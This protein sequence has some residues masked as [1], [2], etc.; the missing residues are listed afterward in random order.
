MRFKTFRAIVSIYILLC[1]VI[2]EKKLIKY[3][4]KSTSPTELKDDKRRGGRWAQVSKFAS[5]GYHDD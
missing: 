2:K 5:L 3:K 1:I 4:K